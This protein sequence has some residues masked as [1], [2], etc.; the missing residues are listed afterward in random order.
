LEFK[1]VE[2][3]EEAKDLASET[4]SV[5]FTVA[6]DVAN[7]FAQLDIAGQISARDLL[8]DVCRYFGFH[9]TEWELALAPDGNA[10]SSIHCHQLA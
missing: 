2:N 5:K 7:R 1:R 4:V 3:L 8:W 9:I 6:N 10:P